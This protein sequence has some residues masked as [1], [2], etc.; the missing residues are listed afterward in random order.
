MYPQPETPAF[1]VF[2]EDQV[3]SLRDLGVE[4]DVLF[5]NGRKNKLNYLLGYPRLWRQL[6]RERYDVIH[7]HYVFSGLVARAALK[8]PVILTHHG[9]EV[10]MTWEKYFCRAT[11]RWFD[12]MIV[13][14]QEMKERL[15][16]PE[17]YVIPCGV[18]MERF[19]P[20]DRA[21]ARRELGLP[22]DRKLVL[23]AGEFFRPEKRFEVVQ[24]AM[25]IVEARDP[26]V[27]L[28]LLSGRPHTTVPVYMNACDAFLLTSDGEGSPMV[29]KEAMSC[30]MP[31][32]S[33]A[34]GDVEDVIGGVEGCF[35]CTQDPEDVADKVLRSL[36]FDKDNEARRERIR[37]MELSAIARRIVGVYEDALRDFGRAMP[38]GEPQAQAGGD[39]R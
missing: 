4:V 18:D 17:A 30:N 31:V 27:E 34:V 33:T 23:W 9:P 8:T 5:M 36:T 11:K 37:P 22:Q 26:S 21:A 13:V 6:L 35:I 12:K 15:G 28:V 10:F 1:A 32:V 2:V 3:R 20:R 25:K 29:I 19:K 39:K 14:S 24:E 7:A 38:S 16:V